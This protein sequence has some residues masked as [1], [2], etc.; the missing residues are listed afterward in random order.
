M[1]LL[2]TPLFNDAEEWRHCFAAELPGLEV[3]I[4]PEVGDPADIEIAVIGWLPDGKLRSF[5]R[6]R[7]IASLL[8]GQDVLLSDPLLPADV[9]I[10]RTSDPNGDP[11]MT[12]VVLLHVLRHHRDLPAYQ[13]AQ[14]RAEWITLPRRRASERRVGLMGLGMIGLAAA[15]AL[16]DLGFQVAGW[17]RRPRSVEG[18]TVFAG[19]AQFGEFLARSEILVNLLPLTTQTRDILRRETLMQLPQ[20]AAVINLGRGP[21]MVE[22]DLIAVLDAGHLAAATLDVFRIEPLPANSPLWRHPKITIIPHA[23][24]RIDARDIAPRICDSIRRLWRGEPLMNL[25]DRARGY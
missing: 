3:R 17:A 18:I 19:E 14:Q 24:R 10:V 15:K 22:A 1:A 16:R 25:V 12:E 4:W 7:L 8:A 2:L 13:A 5:P 9:P 20:G 6:L 21:H 11:M 23:S